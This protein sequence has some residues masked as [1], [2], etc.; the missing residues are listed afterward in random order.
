M[1]TSFSLLPI[2]VAVLWLVACAAPPAPALSEQTQADDELESGPRLSGQDLFKIAC[3][4]CHRIEPDGH[5]DV[6]PNLHGIIGR[7]A[8]SQPGYAY[9]A[10]LQ[11]ADLRWGRDS[12]AAWVAATEIL[13]PGT[14]MAYANILNGEEVSRLIDYLLETAQADTHAGKPVNLP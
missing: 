6:G 13:V 9:S 5:H 4:G 1:R 11:A 3:A 10:A 8:A 12:L 7:A 2:L 14:T